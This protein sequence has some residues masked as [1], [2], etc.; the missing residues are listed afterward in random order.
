MIDGQGGSLRAW[1][2]EPIGTVDLRRRSLEPDL[3]IRLFI[4]TRNS[5]VLAFRA[6]VSSP[7]VSKGLSPS[8]CLL[9]SR[10]TLSIIWPFE[11][12]AIR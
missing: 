4:H 10:T 3:W 9:L 7:L 5:A 6:P 1:Q 12:D 8:G 2:G 11:M